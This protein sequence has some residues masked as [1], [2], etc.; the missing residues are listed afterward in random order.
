VVT[1]HAEVVATAAFDSAASQIT[2]VMSSGNHGVQ[3][4]EAI[5]RGA[6]S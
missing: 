2:D 1:Q 3:G 5:A 4:H 6:Q